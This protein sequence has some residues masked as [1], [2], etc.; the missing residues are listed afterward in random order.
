[1]NPDSSGSPVYLLGLTAPTAS[2]WLAGDLVEVLPRNCPW[3]IEHFLDVGRAAHLRTA[4]SE[5]ELHD[6][7]ALDLPD[8]R[9]LHLDLGALGNPNHHAC[10]TAD[11]IVWRDFVQLVRHEYNRGGFRRTWGRGT[12][13]P[14]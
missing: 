7:G 2:G 10:P 9:D 11:V 1:M 6:L 5:E 13:R 8:Y 3:A 12:W 14:L 4:L